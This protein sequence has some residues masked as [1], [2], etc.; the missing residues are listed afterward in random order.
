MRATQT[1]VTL[2]IAAALS[3]GMLSFLVATPD[4]GGRIDAD[5]LGFARLDTGDV[6]GA[7]GHAA[8]FHRTAHESALGARAARTATRRWL[9]ALPGSGARKTIVPANVRLATG[10]DPGARRVSTFVRWADGLPARGWRVT[11]RDPAA[12]DG[13]ERTW[14]AAAEVQVDV[15]QALTRTRRHVVPVEVRLRGSTAMLRGAPRSWVIEDVVVG[16]GTGWLRAYADPVV[17]GTGVVDIIAPATAHAVARDA[18]ATVESTLV[19]TTKRYSSSGGAAMI[20]VWMVEGRGRVRAVMQRAAPATAGEDDPHAL[21][22][23][24][25][26]GDVVVDLSRFQ[27]ASA[28]VR[29]AAIRHAVAHVATRHVTTEAPALLAEGVPL[30]EQHRVDGR[31]VVPDAQLE[32]LDDAFSTR[33]SGIERLLVAAS[34]GELTTDVERAAATATVAWLLAER[35][36]RRVRALLESLEDGVAPATAVRRTIGLAPRGVELEVAAWVRAQ[37]SAAPA[38]SDE[39]TNPTEEPAE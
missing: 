37:L 39:K 30:V 20:A 26:R 13:A 19:P 35:G 31:I 8:E 4:Q 32:L 11:T 28:S 38:P 6:F 7:M 27:P 14:I 34:T 29:A 9:G 21:A 18:L 10:R 2:V 15:A 1:W 24:D 5:E 23:A 22:W 16:A 17:V 12:V 33:T 25:D 36:P 3:A